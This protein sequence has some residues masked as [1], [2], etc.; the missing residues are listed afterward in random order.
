MPTFKVVSHYFIAVATVTCCLLLGRLIHQYV[1]FLPPALYGM[2]L[3]TLVLSIG[4]STQLLPEH[5]FHQP[6]SVALRYLAIVFVPVTTGVMQYADLILASGLKLVFIGVI[7]TL[8]VISL[9][10]LLSKKLLKEDGNA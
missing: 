10:G 2:L 1:A 4:N 6:M 3:F 7:T 8:S 5:L 9:V